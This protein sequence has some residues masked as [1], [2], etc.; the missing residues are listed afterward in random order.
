MGVEAAGPTALMRPS[1]T[2]TSAPR[3]GAPPVPSK[4]VPQRMAWTAI[5][6]QAGPAAAP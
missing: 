6:G 1:S 3:T 4:S 5:A 2:T